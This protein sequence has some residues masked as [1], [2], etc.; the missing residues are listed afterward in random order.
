VV[1]R[2]TGANGEELTARASEHHVFAAD[3]PEQH[4][5]VLEW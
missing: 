3:A 5:A 1:L 2:A 4:A